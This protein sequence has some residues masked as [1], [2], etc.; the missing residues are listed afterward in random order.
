MIKRSDI[1]V[2]HEHS[3]SAPTVYQHSYTATYNTN[4]RIRTAAKDDH[5]AEE[6]TDYL[7]I[8]I[9]SD[10]KE[11]IEKT[12]NIALTNVRDEAGHDELIRLKKEIDKILNGESE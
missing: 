9:Y 4:Y 5:F 2:T 6:V 3:P 11:P 12:F 7:L 8:G 10:L 1:E